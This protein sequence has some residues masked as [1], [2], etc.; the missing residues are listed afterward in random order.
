VDEG[1]LATLSILPAIYMA[2]KVQIKVEMPMDIV[3]YFTNLEDHCR[4][5]WDFN[6]LSTAERAG[7]PINWAWRPERREVSEYG[8][9]YEWK[10]RQAMGMMDG[11]VVESDAFPPH[12]TQRDV[13]GFPMYAHG[14]EAP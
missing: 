7:H 10:L 6:T 11:E 8:S 12:P 3:L 2:G 1:V 9:L 14:S 5:C 4:V 13:A